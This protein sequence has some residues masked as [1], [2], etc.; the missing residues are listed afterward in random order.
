MKEIG[1]VHHI[2]KVL[3]KHFGMPL[4][5]GC[6]ECEFRKDSN[7]L[8]YCIPWK[9]NMLGGLNIDILTL[10]GLGHEKEIIIN[11]HCVTKV[12]LL[13][14]LALAIENFILQAT[15]EVRKW[16]HRIY[17]VN[18]LYHESIARS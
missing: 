16:F 15:N 3:P 11:D 7:R 5:D 1:N 13:V 6:S 8:R 9:K 4:I 14:A 10:L 12:L 17:G 2:K 18:D